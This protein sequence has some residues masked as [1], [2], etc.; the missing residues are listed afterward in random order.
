VSAVRWSIAAVSVGSLLSATACSPDAAAPATTP[1]PAPTTSVAL[2]VAGDGVLTIG[3]LLPSDD[4]IL[5]A[6]LSSAASVAIERINAAGGVLGRPV[7]VVVADEGETTASAS[8][9]IQALLDGGVDA[10][11]GPASSLV[12]L[13]TLDQIVDAGVVSCSPTASAMSLD[14]FP[15]NGLFFRTVPSDS[16][17]AR[18][19]GEAAIQTGALRAGIVHVD[20]GY[21]RDLADAV[22][23]TLVDGAMAIGDTIPISGLDDDLTAEAQQLIDSGANVAVVLAGE[24]EGI[25]FLSALDALDSRGLATVIVNDTLRSPTEPQRIAALG[26]QLRGRIVG[27]APQAEAADAAA[28]FD[29]SG[30][31]A[32]NAYDCVNLLALAT[33]RAGSDA[34]RAIAEQVSSV[35]SS[36]SAC[37]AFA[38]CLAAIEEGLQVDY[39]GPTGVTEISSRD[40]DPARAVFDRFRFGDD[41]LDVL[42]RQ[43]VVG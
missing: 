27:L 24:D 35:S 37:S 5:G 38:D 16:L 31:F 9:S 15:D 25:R 13:S 20:D 8:E 6:P 3:V 12:A 7:E 2:E 28:P 23:S 39:D 21:G 34:P 40:G 18:A 30:P 22:T 19:I 17:L 36:G 32:T 10:I 41:G 43:V 14:T 33:V 11:V 42:E 4:T 29:P 1:E 26:D